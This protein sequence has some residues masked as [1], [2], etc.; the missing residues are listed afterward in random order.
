MELTIN[1]NDEDD[2]FFALD[3]DGQIAGQMMYYIHNGYYDIFHTEV[4]PGYEGKGVASKMVSM[5]LDI[6]RGK[7]MKVYAR[8]PYTASFLEKHP[9]YDDIIYK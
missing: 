8:C 4:S 1:I 5:V 2:V 7:N 9:E 3:E 6:I